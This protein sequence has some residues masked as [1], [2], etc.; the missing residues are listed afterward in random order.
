MHNA[1]IL[2]GCSEECGLD[3]YALSADKRSYFRQF[4]LAPE[5]EHKVCSMH[6]PC[7]AALPLDSPAAVAVAHTMEFGVTSA[8]KIAQR[9]SEANS[10]I[11][12]NFLDARVDTLRLSLPIALQE[13][14]KHRATLD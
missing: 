3:T 1:A 2:M 4:P 12:R 14:L 5:Q 10:F 8:S 13:W 9:G 11:F 6:R 7:V